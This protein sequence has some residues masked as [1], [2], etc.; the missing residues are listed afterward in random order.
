MW[1]N[2][3]K[4]DSETGL[5]RRE[6]R[7]VGRVVDHVAH[8]ASERTVA[9][10]DQSQVGA[11]P[12]CE[13]R[14]AAR[15]RRRPDCRSCCASR[16]GAHVAQHDQVRLRDRRA[17]SRPVVADVALAPLGRWSCNMIESEPGIGAGRVRVRRRSVGD[18]V[19]LCA[20]GRWSRN[21]IRG[22]SRRLLFLPSAIGGAA[23]LRDRPRHGQGCCRH[24]AASC[25]QNAR[26]AVRALRCAPCRP[27]LAVGALRCAPQRE[28]APCGAQL[29]VRA[30]ECAPRGPRLTVRG[31]RGRPGEVGLPH[32][33]GAATPRRS[34]VRS[35]RPWRRFHRWPAPRSA[36]PPLTA[37][38]G[39]A[40]R[41]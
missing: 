10:H 20:L 9:Q 36:A 30:S 1:R 21:M 29:A 22:S 28:C 14:W 4:S 24:S 38:P 5:G 6:S 25:L 35:A 16:G 8:R 3:I 32:L 39:S 17:M 13:S 18:H 2:L 23:Q 12:R 34:T 40:S 19:A 37:A 15:L 33:R 26:L 31:G 11:G 7:R 27:R 41:W